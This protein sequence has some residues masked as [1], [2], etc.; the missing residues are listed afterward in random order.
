MQGDTSFTN[1]LNE[2]PY[3]DNEAMGS[4][5]LNLQMSAP[6]VE[7]ESSVKKPC[8]GNF[9]TEKDNLLAEAWINTIVYLVEGNEQTKKTYWARIWENYHANK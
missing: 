7:I 9:S 8:C 1:L 4:L 2:G 5:D 3:F 6:N